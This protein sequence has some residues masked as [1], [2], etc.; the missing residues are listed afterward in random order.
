M[1]FFCFILMLHWPHMALAVAQRG[2][3]GFI[4]EALDAFSTLGMFLL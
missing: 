4:Y 2:W 1:S 3:G